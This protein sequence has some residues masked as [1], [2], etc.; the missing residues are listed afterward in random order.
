[1]A[2]GRP[3]TPINYLNPGPDDFK[4]LTLFYKNVEVIRK[5]EI[6]D[7]KTYN[8]LPGIVAARQKAA[9]EAATQAAVDRALARASVPR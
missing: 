4:G 3:A 9:E 1:M 7:A 8:E 6:I 2:I 5:G